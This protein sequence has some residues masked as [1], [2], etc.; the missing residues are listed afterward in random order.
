LKKSKIFN[1]K[2]RFLSMNEFVFQVSSAG[3]DD[4]QG[5]TQEK[6]SKKYVICIF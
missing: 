3:N 5:S 4:E 6:I 2:K 1:Q